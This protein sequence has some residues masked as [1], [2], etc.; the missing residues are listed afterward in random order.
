MAAFK[1]HGVIV[2]DD[3]EFH[4]KV[5]HW[6]GGPVAGGGCGGLSVTVSTDPGKRR[7]LIVEFP[8]VEFGQ[9]KPKSE[10]GFANRLQGCIE[11]AI[12]DGYRPNSR[13]RPWIW[14]AE[15]V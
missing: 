15:P 11:A 2:I 6:V 4:W 9:G 12:A 13:G 1:D 3:D 14:E 5:R 7:E 8:Y 10:I